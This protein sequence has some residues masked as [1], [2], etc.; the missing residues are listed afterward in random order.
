MYKLLGVR[1]IAT[2]SYHPNGN[3]GVERV[4]HTMAHMLSMVVNERQNDWDTHLPHAESAYNNSVSAATSLAPNEVHMG[5]LPRMP[6]T[7][8][9]LPNAGG[10]Q[11]LARDQ[12][13]HCDLAK[14]RQQRAYE[15]VREQHVLTVTRIEGRNSA[16]LQG[17]AQNTSL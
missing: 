4:N 13:A 17:T 10:H 16:L 5:R 2:S 3:G 6:L 1:K 7:V 12:L 8:F 15:L 11:S 14:D 9:E